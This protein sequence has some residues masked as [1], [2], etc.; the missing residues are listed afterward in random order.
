M[1]IGNPWSDIFYDSW[2][3]PPFVYFHSLCSYETYQLVVEYCIDNDSIAFTEVF[4]DYK[5]R[6]LR[7]AYDECDQALQQMY[8]EM[9]PVNNYDI[10]TPCYGGLEDDCTDNTPIQDYFNDEDVQ[11]A[12]HAEISGKT[13]YTW[14]SCGDVNYTDSWRSVLSLYP[15]LMDA[16]HVAVYSGDV[17]YNVP[18][19]GTQMWVDAFDQEIV[20]PWNAWYLEGQVAGY[21]KKFEKITYVTVLGS[22]HMVPMYTPAAAKELLNSYFNSTF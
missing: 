22:G 19:I 15:K 4:A 7:G 14:T 9:G 10:Y 16:I 13:N 21:Y 12:I 11:T 6:M 8:D 1:L 18:A 2:S 20:V 3:V 17:T 5:P